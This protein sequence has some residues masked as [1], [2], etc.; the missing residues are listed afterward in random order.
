MNVWIAGWNVIADLKAQKVGAT[1]IARKLG[2]G[3]RLSGFGWRL[4]S[5]VLYTELCSLKRKARSVYDRHKGV[6]TPRN[7]PAR[8]RIGL[9]RS[10]YHLAVKLNGS[11]PGGWRWQIHCAGR[12]GAI[13]KSKTY[14][15]SM[16]AATKAGK[17][18]LNLLLN[19]F[20]PYS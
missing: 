3:F 18:A 12:S 9:K 7:V 1:E 15:E 8:M 10:D 16:S 2:I 5:S 19:R 4:N 6:L 17:E 20:Y 11:S 14:F 13:E